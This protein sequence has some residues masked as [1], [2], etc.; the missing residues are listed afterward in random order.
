[1]NIKLTHKTSVMPKRAHFDDVGLDCYARTDAVIE[2][3]ATVI[4]P[5]GFAV[6]LPLGIEMQIR[7]R[8][9]MAAKGIW[10]HTGTVDSGYRGEVSAILHNLTHARYY[11]SAGERV[12]QAVL[13]SFRSLPLHE[14][15]SLAPS[16]R[17]AGGFGSTGV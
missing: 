4:V 2:A 13:A 9:S 14:V 12:A 11:I 5:L 16:K 8:S 10:C 6:E 17:G 1:M 7:G 3:G 15:D